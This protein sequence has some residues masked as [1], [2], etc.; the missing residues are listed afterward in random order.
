M[1]TLTVSA[2]VRPDR[3]AV[4]CDIA[5]PEWMDSCR[6][7]LEIFS[8]VWGGH[9]NVIIPTDGNTIEPLFWQLL[10]E[11][12]P[13]YICAYRPTLRDLEERAPQAFEQQLAQQIAS[14]GGDYEPTQDMLD[15]TRDNLR[16]VQTSSF[17]VSMQLAQ[18]LKARIAPFFHQE[19]IVQPGFW[20]AGVTLG[21]PHTQIL[22]LVGET[23]HP[24]KIIL[25]PRSLEP[26][27]SLWYSAAIG[28][29]NAELTSALEQSGIKPIPVGAGIGT[30]DAIEE[31]RKLIS[32]VVD[33]GSLERTPSLYVTR[34]DSP[35][36][37]TIRFT[38]ADLSLLNLG[39]Y[40]QKRSNLWAPKAIAIAGN[41][42]SD[43]CLYL[44]LSRMRERVFWIFPPI[45]ESALSGA[46]TT[47]GNGPATTFANS[48]R[49]ATE[50][51]QQYSPG[52]DLLSATL[53]ENRLAAVRAEI[54]VAAQVPLHADILSG[55]AAAIP[56]HP[57]RFFERSNASKL[58][59]VQLPDTRLI[60]LFETP[61][62]T[63]FRQINP[64]HHR[65][66]TELEL[67][68]YQPARHPALGNWYVSGTN[69]GTNEVR[70][71][72]A[73]VAYFCPNSM[74]M[75]GQDI[76]AVTVRPNIL[77]PEATQVFAKVAE[78][79]GLAVTTSDKGFY[80]QDAIAK[81]GGLESAGRFFRSASGRALVAAYL[82]AT[83]NKK[84]QYNRGVLLGDRRYLSAAD[85]VRAL[86]TVGEAVSYIDELSRKGILYRGFIFQCE[87][88][89]NSAWFSLRDIGDRFTC[90]R[91]HREQ[92]YTSKHW[93]MPRCQPSI[94]YQLDEIVYQGISN[95][96]QVP[97]LTLDWLH[98]SAESSF[99]YVEE[100]EFRKGEESKLLMECDVNCV[101]DGILTVG[102]AKRVD[103]LDQ[104]R[105][106]EVALIEKYRV[107]AQ[108]LGA[109]RVVFATEA[110]NW[111]T[112]TA[113]NIAKMFN[114]SSIQTQLLTSDEL[115]E[116]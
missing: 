85:L 66:I 102:E 103:R 90:L 84:G 76:D 54:G 87:F 77:V 70:T 83:P 33:R 91:C 2:S 111:D 56:D 40:K 21:Y 27:E 12:D 58:R 29:C 98:R 24:D 55:P 61:K 105:S 69:Q 82:D 96:M 28:S 107:L 63:S 97:T 47:Y 95:N 60:E 6:H 11:F 72:A 68:S 22:D 39:W 31:Q 113:A 89:R 71:S 5:D 74:I 65:W 25:P 38:P 115:F 59:L 73:G 116:T 86:K 19:Y 43:F 101:I 49:M 17:T 78:S 45:T 67:Q 112:T 20:R 80:A 23:D 62:P 104:K 7:I 41:T 44:A 8:S 57:V 36:P 108:S 34:P 53:D 4:L 100:L 32:F 18:E 94:Y 14:W 42:V 106:A 109:R 81:L 99:Q 64:S 15:R 10:E 13:D 92:V 75:G 114:G 9:A 51:V 110:K 35:L 48:L 50:Y 46:D 3:I 26:G 37:E 16:R 1:Q 88:C 79:A 52:L 30:N 93:K